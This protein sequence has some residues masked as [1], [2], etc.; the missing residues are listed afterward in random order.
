[1]NNDFEDLLED[2]LMR[3]TPVISLGKR[4]TRRQYLILSATVSL[5]L[6][7][8]RSKVERQALVDWSN[9]TL[10]LMISGD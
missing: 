6:E 8:L 7:S 9:H 5:K 4:I 1:M 10:P 2:I 3:K